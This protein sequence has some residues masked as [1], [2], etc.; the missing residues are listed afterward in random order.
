M[1]KPK[2]GKPKV[3]EQTVMIPRGKMTQAQMLVDLV[4]GLIPN[5]PDGWDIAAVI[6]VSADDMDSDEPRICV[7]QQVA[8]PFDNENDLKELA[9]S[10]TRAMLNSEVAGVMGFIL[11]DHRGDKLN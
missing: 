9:A 10:I 11:P 1:D 8:A 2:K 4:A 7:N 6:I 3:T 5:I